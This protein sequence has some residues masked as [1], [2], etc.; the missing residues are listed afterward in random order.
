MQRSVFWAQLADSVG[1]H[2]LHIVSVMSG[3][4]HG[5]MRNAVGW[6]EFQV[7]LVHRMFLHRAHPIS[8]PKGCARCGIEGRC[9]KLLMVLWFSCVVLQWTQMI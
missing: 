6:C 5:C 8:A 4:G 7:G 9:A 3:G 1:G 2:G